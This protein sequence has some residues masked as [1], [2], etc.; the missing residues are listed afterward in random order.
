MYEHDTY[1]TVSVT[2]FTAAS[3]RRSCILNLIGYPI[4]IGSNWNLMEA[5]FVKV[6]N[7]N[8]IIKIQSNESGFRAASVIF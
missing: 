3:H 8:F 1:L 5:S 2:E 4:V 7:I 6:N